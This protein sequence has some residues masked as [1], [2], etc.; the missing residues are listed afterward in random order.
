MTQLFNTPE[1]GRRLKE[2]LPQLTS[3]YYW[4]DPTK[5][6]PFSGLRNQNPYLPLPSQL[7]RL[8]DDERVPALTLQELR[9]VMIGECDY[10]DGDIAEMLYSHTAP[11]LATWFIELLEERV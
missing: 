5:T 3:T 1:Q 9:D 7:T 2:L 4:I 10:Y 11:K 8:S 6:R